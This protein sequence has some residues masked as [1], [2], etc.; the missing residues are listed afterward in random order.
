[1][2]RLT[3]TFR[4]AA[5]G[6]WPPRA[7]LAVSREGRWT[8]LRRP[9]GRLSGRRKAQNVSCKWISQ[10]R[11]GRILAA[12]RAVIYNPVDP[13]A[14]PDSRQHRPSTTCG[15]RLG[16]VDTEGMRHMP[17]SHAPRSTHRTSIRSRRGHQFKVRHRMMGQCGF[18]F[19]R[20]G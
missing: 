12:D 4:G 6:R 11:D 18:A 13:I 19:W 1:V 15:S 14:A 17:S 5:C 2:H 3:R 16:L 10:R 8:A 20:S 9:V 7:R